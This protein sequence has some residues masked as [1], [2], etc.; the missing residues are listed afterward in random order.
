MKLS[1][2]V[3]SGVLGAVLVYVIVRVAGALASEPSDLCTLLG[4]SLTGTDNMWTWLLGATAQLVLGIVA[5]LVYASIFEWVTQRAGAPIGLLVALVHVVVAGIGTGFLPAG[6]LIEAGLAPPGAF[7]EYR[8]IAVAS[9]FVIA[10]LAFGM[11]IGALYGR[12]R[13][14][15][16]TPRTVW[17]EA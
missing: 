6:R 11:I 14:K 17:R 7:M 13:Q 8:G 5:S 4:S 12:P 2:A 16:R 15:I 3:V 1:R 9:A 10:H